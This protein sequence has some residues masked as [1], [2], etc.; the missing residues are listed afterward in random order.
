MVRCGD[1]PLKRDVRPGDGLFEMTATINEDDGV[2]EF[3]LKS[4]FY[5]GLGKAEPGSQPMPAHV[6]WLHR[7][8][9][10]TWMESAVRNTMT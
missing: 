5:Q 3:G 4:A 2:A 6:E 7:L 1:S 8:Y 9:T 10:K